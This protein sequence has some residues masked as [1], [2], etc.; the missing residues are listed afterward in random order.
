MLALLSGSILGFCV[1]GGSDSSTLTFSVLP[2][3]RRSEICLDGVVSLRAYRGQ[4]IGLLA[5]LTGLWKRTRGLLLDYLGT[6]LLGG[7]RLA[8][9]AALVTSASPVPVMTFFPGL[10]SSFL[11]YLYAWYW[12]PCPFSLKTRIQ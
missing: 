11:A 3:G 7:E 8:V 5:I 6:L 10:L 9:L 4:L 12:F 2:R 1:P